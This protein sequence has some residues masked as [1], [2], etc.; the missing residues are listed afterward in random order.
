MLSTNSF[1][2]ATQ[3]CCKYFALLNTRTVLPLSSKW[4]IQPFKS[5]QLLLCEHVHLQS[6]SK[7]H[8]L[9]LILGWYRKS[10]RT[11]DRDEQAR[12][13]LT[14][15][16]VLVFGKQGPLWR[17]HSRCLHLTATHSPWKSP[18]SACP[19]LTHTRRQG[20]LCL[21]HNN[22]SLLA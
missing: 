6:L 11:F 15:N 7:P 22:P 8:R 5:G 12:S 16:G 21:L 10:I 19:L 17:I 9:G 18:S 13:H 4:G 14:P 20:T 2:W 3:I 1:L